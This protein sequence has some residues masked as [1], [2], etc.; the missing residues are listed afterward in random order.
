[1][2]AN[3]VTLEKF[4]PALFLSDLLFLWLRR[5]SLFQNHS[6]ERFT[7]LERQ[8]KIRIPS[9]TKKGK[10]AEGYIRRYVTG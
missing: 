7:E 1:M 9:L 3:L 4:L 10:E 2:A 6:A 5:L 8:R